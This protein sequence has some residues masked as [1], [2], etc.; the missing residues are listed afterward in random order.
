MADLAQPRLYGGRIRCDIGRRLD[1]IE[2]EQLSRTAQQRTHFV[3]LLLEPGI[4]HRS[5]LPTALRHDNSAHPRSIEA[6][7]RPGQSSADSD[8]TDEKLTVRLAGGDLRSAFGAPAPPEGDQGISHD[9]CFQLS[10]RLH[11]MG[12][13]WTVARRVVRG[14]S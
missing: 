10:H 14:H 5:T 4:S 11:P 3:Q 1:G 13:R 2:A 7:I 8:L 9:P 6:N 12:H